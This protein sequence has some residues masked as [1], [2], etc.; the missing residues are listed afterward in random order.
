VLSFLFLGLGLYLFPALFVKLAEGEQPRPSGIVFAWANAFLL[1]DARPAMEEHWTANLEDAVAQ[2]GEYQKRTGKVKPVFIDFTRVNCTNCNLNENDV[3]T[4]PD[5]RALFKPYVLV[6]LYTDKVPIQYYSPEDRQAVAGISARQ[7]ADAAASARFQKK[8]F[9]TEQLPLYVILEPRL[10][11][12]IKIVGT[13]DEGRIM[14]ES[15]FAAFLRQP[16]E[17][18]GTTLASR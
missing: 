14:N 3:F 17:A 9:D 7:E 11:D 6:K 8:V 5:I 12:T 18:I 15:A 2:A 10:D 1:P 4:K 16:Q 13:Y